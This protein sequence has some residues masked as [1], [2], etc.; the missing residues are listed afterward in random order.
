LPAVDF[1]RPSSRYLG[2][3][4]P[5]GETFP[6]KDAELLQHIANQIAIGVENALSYRQILTG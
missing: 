1:S 3:G 4:E 5:A 6:Q 2:G